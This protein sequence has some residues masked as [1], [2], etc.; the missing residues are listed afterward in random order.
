MAEGPQQN[1]VPG[2]RHRA[3]RAPESAWFADLLAPH[4]ANEPDGIFIR[5]SEIDGD[6]G[7]SFAQ[8]KL[9]LIGHSD[10]LRTGRGKGRRGNNSA[11][12]R[13]VFGAYTDDSRYRYFKFIIL[14]DRHP[15]ETIMAYSVGKRMA[16]VLPV[17][18]LC[19]RWGFLRPRGVGLEQFSFV[20]LNEIDVGHS[21]SLT[22]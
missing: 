6:Y 10:L 21:G 16:I 17:S 15:S 14:H 12:S 11:R 18:N 5:L 8:Q 4:D 13:L 19:P 1:A 2:A 3:R 20:F 7:G 9:A 22:N